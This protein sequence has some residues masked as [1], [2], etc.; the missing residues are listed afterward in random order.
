MTDGYAANPDRL[1]AEGARFDD[2]AGR[3][4]QIHRTLAD[5]LSATG[6]C[7]GTDAVGASFAD[8]HAAPAE[9]TLTALSSLTESLGAV[10]TRFTAT[11]TAY[12][13]AEDAA[14]E[15]LR[16]TAPDA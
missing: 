13:G 10:G 6:E 1:A 12:T 7:W 15:H 3:V 9:T 8:A 11:G 5:A 2:L 16:A 14:V 4:G